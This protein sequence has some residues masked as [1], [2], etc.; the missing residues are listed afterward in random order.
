MAEVLAAPNG[1][2][3]NGSED[4]DME[5]AIKTNSLRF[6]TGL[7]LPPPEIKCEQLLLLDIPC[8]N[9]TCRS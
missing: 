8:T 3:S 5:S 2:H 9:K 7:I 4:H 1:L 6:S